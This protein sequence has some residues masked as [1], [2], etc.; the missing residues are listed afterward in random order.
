MQIKGTLHL[1]LAQALQKA[2]PEA[3]PHCTAG[4]LKSKEGR[5]AGGGELQTGK[6]SREQEHTSDLAVSGQTFC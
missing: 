6:E 1:T 2:K 5:G 3:V 4:L